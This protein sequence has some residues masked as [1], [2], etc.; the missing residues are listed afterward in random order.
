LYQ[1]LTG[2]KLFGFFPQETTIYQY[3]ADQSPRIFQGTLNGKLLECPVALS[4]FDASP[5]AAT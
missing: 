2:S 5:A 1:P 4:R 3:S